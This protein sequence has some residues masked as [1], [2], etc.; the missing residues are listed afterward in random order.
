METK[1]SIRTKYK[2]LRNAMP[3]NIVREESQR[4]CQNISTWEIFQK[5]QNCFFY[6]PLGKEASLL[7]FFKESIQKRAAFPRVRGEEMDF[8]EV[9]STDDFQEGYFHVMEPKDEIPAMDLAELEQEKTIVF[10]PGLVFDI[11]GGR[12]GY[13]KGFY[14]RFFQKYKKV[15]RVGIAL[16]CQLA[17]QVPMEAYDIPMDYLVTP[18]KIYKVTDNRDENK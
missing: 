16:S 14:D 12:S 10:T 1:A 8:C 13:G 17:E 7:P 2:I 3:E 15:I 9:N 5:A 18:E 11:N 4:I 6:Y